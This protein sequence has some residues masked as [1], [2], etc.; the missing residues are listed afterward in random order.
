[1]HF[2]AQEYSKALGRTITYQD[3]PVEPWRDALLNR[4]WPVHVVNHPAALADL[5]RAGRFDRTSDD[6]RTPTGQEPLRVQ[7][8]VREKAATFTPSAKGALGPSDARTRLPVP[9][10]RT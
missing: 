7:E 5:H 10:R 2:F 1:M 4:R 6:V 8:V 9:D 3:I